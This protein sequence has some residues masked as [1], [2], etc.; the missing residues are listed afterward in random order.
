MGKELTEEQKE[1][2]RKLSDPNWNQFAGVTGAHTYQIPSGP[3]PVNPVTGSIYFDLDA[4]AALVYD[5]TQWI[6]MA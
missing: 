6:R 5:G 1:V 2:W 3:G 4:N